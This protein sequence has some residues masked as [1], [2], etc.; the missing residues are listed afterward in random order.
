MISI[1]IE[2]MTFNS[3]G[4]ETYIMNVSMLKR[5]EKVQKAFDDNES[6][7]SNKIFSHL[8]NQIF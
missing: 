4:L 1:L 2:G 7:L 3:G 5:L 6:L 8:I